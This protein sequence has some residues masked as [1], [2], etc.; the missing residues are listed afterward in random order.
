MFKGTSSMGVK[1]GTLQQDRQGAQVVGAEHHV[2]PRRLVHDDL[3]ILLRHA[4]ADRDLHAGRD[5]LD[6]LEVAEVAVE[7]VVGVLAHGAGVE[8]DDVGLLPRGGT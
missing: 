8:H 3:A 5:V 4:A 6:R 1:P 2:H 7:P